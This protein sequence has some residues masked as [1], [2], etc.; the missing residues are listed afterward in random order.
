MLSAVEAITDAKA[1]FV[2][3]TSYAV[4]QSFYGL[5]ELM[6]EVYAPQGGHLASGE[7][8]L[9]EEAGGRALSTSLFSRWTGG[10]VHG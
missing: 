10:P 8:V 7:L 1:D 6:Q 4:R 5:H 3:L 2:V 9:R